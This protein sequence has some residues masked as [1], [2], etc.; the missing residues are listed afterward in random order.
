VSHFTDNGHWYSLSMERKRVRHSSV[1]VGIARRRARLF[2]DHHFVDPPQRRQIA[3]AH[4]DWSYGFG[5][6]G[7][8]S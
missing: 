2:N 6:F 4:A 5:K 1:Q 8:L 3:G 7:G